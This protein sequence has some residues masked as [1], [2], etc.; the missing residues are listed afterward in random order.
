[1]KILFYNH[2]GQVSGAERV[3]LMILARLDQ[4]RF[5]PVVICPEEGPLLSMATSLGVP[6]QSVPG[7]EA[8]FTWRVDRLLR[9]LKSFRFGHQTTA[10]KS[11]PYQARSDSTLTAFA[12]DWWPRRPHSA[13]EPESCGIYTIFFRVIR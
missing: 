8:R 5:D 10:T 2:T 3:L 11:H 9:Y 1:M 12:R 4:R 13:W 7:L 6:V